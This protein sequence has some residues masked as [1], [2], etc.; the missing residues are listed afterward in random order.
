MVGVSYDPVSVLKVFAEANEIE[1]PL[2]SDEGSE[3][4]RAYGI[5]NRDGLP[6]PGTYL[7]NQDGIVQAV[8]FLDGYRDRHQNDEL[9]E[10]AKKIEKSSK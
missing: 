8:L 1:F 2:L 7:L 6:H 4:I 5:H 9:V 3:T 10:A